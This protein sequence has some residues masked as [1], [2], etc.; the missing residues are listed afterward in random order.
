MSNNIF[1]NLQTEG[2]EGE[3]DVLGGGG[4]VESGAYDGVVE[5]AYVG[6][7]QSSD[8]Q[9]VTFNIKLDNGFYV[10]E[11][12]YVTNK[13]GENFYPDKNDAK[14][15]HLLPGFPHGGLSVSSDHRPWADG[16]GNGRE[17][18]QSVRL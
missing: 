8:A 18:R 17:G 16:S 9:N 1:G 14:K 12:I 7:S 2:F 4:T 11:T 10:R 3:K 6:K 13:K 15:K 5:L